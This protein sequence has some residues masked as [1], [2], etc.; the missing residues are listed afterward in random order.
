MVC[1][2]SRD[3]RL[4]IVGAGVSVGLLALAFLAGSLLFG[5]RADHPIKEASLQQTPIAVSTIPTVTSSPVPSDTAAPMRS[6]ETP[7]VA[8]PAKAV[9]HSIGGS[10]IVRYPTS[11]K[12]LG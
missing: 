9:H 12:K 11:D 6:S 7:S 4:L 2:S 5:V 1:L 8:A 10:F 3:V